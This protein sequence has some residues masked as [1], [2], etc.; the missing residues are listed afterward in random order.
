MRSPA[1][2]SL[3]ALLLATTA[4]AQPPVGAVDVSVLPRPAPD[5]PVQLTAPRGQIVTLTAGKAKAVQW[6][7]F[8]TAGADLV[9]SPSGVAYFTATA[10]G[11]Y[12]VVAAADNELVLIVVTVG[13]APG[14]DPKPPAP[15]PPA[16]KPG[17]PLYDRLK[18][19]FDADQT[20]QK[21]GRAH[22]LAAL[23]RQAAALVESP[24]VATS[25]DLL[26]RVREA[27]A[28]LIGPDALPA[29]RKAA[30]AELALVLG[31][32]APLTADQRAAAAKLFRELAAVLESF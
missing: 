12:R 21:Q 3:L 6:R 23:Y 11:T 32:D 15:K 27:A 30:A 2:A 28:T 17:G 5:K 4:V 8:D 14:P 29:V 24:D 10:D 13:T 26:R 25:G 1:H 20:P 18:A 31:E 22:D 9:A 19:A 7:L 16:P